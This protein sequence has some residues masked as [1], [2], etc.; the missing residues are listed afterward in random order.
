MAVEIYGTSSTNAA[1]VKK[2][3]DDLVSEECISKDVQSSHLAKLPVSDQKTIVNLSQSI[4][5]SVLVAGP[6]RWTVSGKKDD[7]FDAMLKINN[8]IQEVRD[9]EIRDGEVK[10]LRQTLRWEVVR[11]ETWK[12]LDPSIS[13]E[14]E[15][16]YHKK[17]KTF[18]YQENGQT[19]TVDFKE[20]TLMNNGKKESCRIKRT[21][22][23]DCDTGKCLH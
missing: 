17:H 21:L 5:V 12:P 16:S 15:L 4:E 8:L 6:D 2:Y 23:G 7:V 14:V 22:L 10:R 3:L 13:Y 11:G 19:Y 18:Q 1:K 9:G 20:M